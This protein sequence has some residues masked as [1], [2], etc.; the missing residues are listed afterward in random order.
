MNSGLVFAIRKR[1]TDL[2][3][4]H[5]TKPQV[6]ADTLVNH[7]FVHAATTC[8]DGMGT[9]REVFVPKHAP[10]TQHLEAFRVVRIDEE[11]IS[12]VVPISSSRSRSR[13]LPCGEPLVQPHV[14]PAA[15]HDRDALV[16]RSGCDLGNGLAPCA[17]ATSGG[18]YNLR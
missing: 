10:H 17:C 9:D 8:V 15:E 6:L 12:H 7:L 14:L 3:T 16:Q 5:R 11:L 1:S 4:M 13:I 18:L 2:E